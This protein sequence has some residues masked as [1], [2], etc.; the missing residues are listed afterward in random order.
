MT[1]DHAAA[2]RLGRAVH[3]SRARAADQPAA[4]RF[5]ERRRGRV[6][7]EDAEHGAGRPGGRS[8]AP[9]V[10]EHSGHARTVNELFSGVE[11]VGD[12]TGKF[13]V[14]EGFP[15]PGRV[16]DLEA[17]GAWAPSSSRRASRI[18]EG[19]C[20]LD[21]GLAGPDDLAAPAEDPGGVGLASRTASG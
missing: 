7:G 17:R 8:D 9:I 20:T 6:P 21:L 16:T 4:R 12:V 19:I 18:H 1:L 11:W 5:L 14:T 3:P 15:M 10:Y 13:V 2:R